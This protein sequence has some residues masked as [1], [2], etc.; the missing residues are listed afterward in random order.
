MKCHGPVRIRRPPARFLRPSG[1]RRPGPPRRRVRCAS[2]RG[3]CGAGA[4]RSRAAPAARLRSGGR[5]ARS[6]R[7]A[8]R[9]LRL[10]GGRVVAAEGFLAGGEGDGGVDEGHGELRL[11]GSV[12]GLSGPAMERPLFARILRGRLCRRGR[13]LAPA[14]LARLIARMRL[15]ARGKR[16]AQLA[17]RQN[18]GRSAPGRRGRDAVHGCRFPWTHHST[19]FDN[20]ILIEKYYIN[21]MNDCSRPS[22]P[23]LGGLP[24]SYQRSSIGTDCGAVPTACPRES[25]VR[26]DD[27]KTPSSHESEVEPAGITYLIQACIRRPPALQRGLL[28]PSP[29]YRYPHPERVEGACPASARA[30]R[31]DA[32]GG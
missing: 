12:H 21:F 5:S 4:R 28:R 27:M 10:A 16:R 20:A 19:L 29:P 23:R 25:G 14:R 15:R 1:H 3:G 31:G 24:D 32:K 18:R 17:C 2:T 8:L 26:G 22:L 30:G 6:S 13:A 7:P 11:L 9:R